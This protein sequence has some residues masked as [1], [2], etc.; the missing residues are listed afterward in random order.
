[1]VR[2]DGNLAACTGGGKSLEKLIVEC[3][4]QAIRECWCN[5]FVLVEKFSLP[6]NI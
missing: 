5:W 1:M 6:N 3:V 4:N 2:L